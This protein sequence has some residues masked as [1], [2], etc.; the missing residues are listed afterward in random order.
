VGVLEAGKR[1][2]LILVDGDPCTDMSAMR[3]IHSVVK[4]GQV[5]VRD[6]ALV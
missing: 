2:D 5:R 1:A 3:R 4:D 6:G